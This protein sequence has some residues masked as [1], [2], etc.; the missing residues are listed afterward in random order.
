MKNNIN[1]RET[2]NNYIIKVRRKILKIYLYTFCKGEI[3]Q[4]CAYNN[5]KYRY[6]SISYG[7]ELAQ[8]CAYKIFR[9]FIQYLYISLQHFRL[10]SAEGI[11]PHIIYNKIYNMCAQ[12]CAISTIKVYRVGLFLEILFLRGYSHG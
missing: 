11:S 4:A 2:L 12:A 1:R 7:V 10:V 3:A 6:P 9:Q 8:A 5:K